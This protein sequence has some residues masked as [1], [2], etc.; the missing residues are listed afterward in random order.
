MKKIFKVIFKF[1]VPST[2]GRSLDFRTKVADIKYAVEEF[3][4]SFDFKEVKLISIRQQEIELLSMI[5]V[6]DESVQVTAKYLS[7]FSKR[8][9]HDRS[10]SIFSRENAKLFTASSF[11]DVTNKYL[12]IYEKIPVIPEDL[13]K[14]VH[15]ELSK[16]I[17]EQMDDASLIKALEALINIQDVGEEEIKLNR[18]KGIIEIKRILLSLLG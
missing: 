16:D 17:N 13:Q 18:K 12:D 1:K 8:L 11:N 4:T 3:N 15:P 9:Y 5:N 2:T 7:V 6:K 14:S 10:W